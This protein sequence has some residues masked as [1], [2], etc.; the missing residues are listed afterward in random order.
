MGTL[1]NGCF[2]KSEMT[3]QTR[4]SLNALPF[5]VALFLLIAVPR[6]EH[7]LFP[8]VKDFV[9]TGMVKEPHAVVIN[10][11]MHKVRDCNFVGVQVV[12][13]NDGI[14]V[15]APLIFLDTQNNNATRPKGTQGWGPWQVVVKAE[16][17]DAIKLTS[18]HRCHPFWATDTVLA[19]VPLRE[20]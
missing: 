5:V 6:I 16:A 11:Y 20:H 2:D 18:T 9:V 7:F 10:G 3:N 8:V 13:V 19:T 12:T 1:H 4:F 14:E 15:D 17:A